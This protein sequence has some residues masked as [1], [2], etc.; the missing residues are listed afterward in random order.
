MKHI[1]LIKARKPEKFNYCKFGTYKDKRGKIQ[2]LID[3][4][5]LETSGYEMFNAVVSLNINDEYDKSVY[6]FLKD[7]PLIKKFIVEDVSATERQ[8][9]ETS[10]LSAQAVTTAS[11]LKEQELKDFALLLGLDSTLQEMLLRA[12]IIQHASTKPAKFLEQLNDID[13][14]HRIFLKKAFNEKLLTKVN[15]VWK[16]NTLNI[17]MTDDQAIV[18]LKDNGDT[19]ALLKHQLRTGVTPVEETIE[20]EE[21]EQHPLRAGSAISEIEKEIDNLKK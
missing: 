5:G 12:K 6:E 15:G 18:W 17:G 2:K 16:H 3:I 20:L 13:K 14:E 19:Y 1:V 11:Q 10:I 21:V 7:H 9:A 8:N 4:N